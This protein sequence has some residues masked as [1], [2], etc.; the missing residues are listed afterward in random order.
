MG[1]CDGCKRNCCGNK[2]EGLEKAFKHENPD[3][4]DQI[5]LSQE[6][7]DRITDFGGEKYIEYKNG[8]PYITLNNDCSCRAFKD[9]KC[10]IYEVRPDVCKL[11]PF[12]FD[13]F[14]GILVDK[15]CKGYVQEDFN[16]AS[17]DEKEK[18]FNL[19]KNRIELFE[20]TSK[21]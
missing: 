13:P 19:V 15:N 7:V 20:K 3:I 10:E 21:K 1:K 6:E 2:F 4:F 5:L 18:I 12:Y 9:G 14:A 11:Y 8:L 17:A 16:N